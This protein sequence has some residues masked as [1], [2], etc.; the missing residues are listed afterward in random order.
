MMT[1]HLFIE[2]KRV[3]EE[4]KKEL[5]CLRNVIHRWSELETD[6]ARGELMRVE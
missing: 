4:N 6:A 3:E 2:R 1:V 5:D